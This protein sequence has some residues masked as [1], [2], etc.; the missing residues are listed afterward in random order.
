M[1]LYPALLLGALTVGVAWRT[2][3]ANQQKKDEKACSSGRSSDARISGCT[4][5]I[6]TANLTP[7]GL[8]AA[9]G[10]RGNAYARAGRYDNAL[11]DYDQAIGIDPKQAP[12]FLGRGTIFALKGTYQRALDDYDQALRL[13]PNFAQVYV[14]RGLLLSK[15]GQPERAAG[16]F[17]KA[18]Q[19]NPSMPL[20]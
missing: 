3:E 1:R 17:A 16:D 13:D 12:L 15:L 5:L 4:S 18:R 2:A 19:L 9:L 8:I 11:A 6:R 10:N 20:P 14:V 7:S